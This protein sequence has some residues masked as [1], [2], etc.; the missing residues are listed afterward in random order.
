[1]K[2]TKTI[3]SAMS[4]LA[5][6]SSSV[7]GVMAAETTGIIRT[8]AS[9]APKNYS[10]KVSIDKDKVVKSS[11]EQFKL[12]AKAS[13]ENYDVKYYSSDIKVASVNS[14]GVVRLRKKGKAKIVA[15]CN[16]VKKVCTVKVKMPKDRKTE[17]SATGKLKLGSSTMSKIASGIGWQTQY[18][19]PSSTIM[20][21][22]YSFAYAYYQVT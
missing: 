17:S 21:S 22:A 3:I 10:L 16:G 11:G 13:E 6:V 14:N 7:F 2:K 20:C 9:F 12:N 1:M 5:I 18:A 19:Y 4:A 8:D 15:E